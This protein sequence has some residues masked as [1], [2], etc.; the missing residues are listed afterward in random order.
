MLNN[1]LNINKKESHNITKENKCHL[2]NNNNDRKRRHSSII[3]NDINHKFQKDQE[4]Q[5]VR[6]NSIFYF[7]E[8]D[9]IKSMDTHMYNN[10][11]SNEH[12]N[13]IHSCSDNKS[14]L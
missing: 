5:H 10:T 14:F 1:D 2:H 8:K 11:Y 3:I 12:N 9:D 4:D 7:P 13:Y 6:V